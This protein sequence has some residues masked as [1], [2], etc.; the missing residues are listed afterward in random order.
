ML[1]TGATGFI[2]SRL[3]ALA[4]ARGYKVRTLS[5][6]DWSES[7]AVPVENRYF[8]SLPGKVPAVALQGTDLVVHCAA[9]VSDGERIAR[10]VNVDGTVQLARQAA[11]A[12]VRTFIFLSSQSA[13]LDAPSAYGKTKF[14]A[15]Q[16]LAA[17]SGLNIIILRPGL[18]VGPGRGGLYRRLERT[19]RE[20]PVLPLLDG[21]RA[22]V[23]PIH[24]DDLCE[25]IFRCDLQADQ[26]DRAVLC[27]GDVQGLPLKDFLQ[28]IA[29]VQLGHPKWA[30]DI[31]LWPVEL[32]VRLAEMLKLP[33]PVD[34][35]NLQGLRAVQRMDTAPTLERLGLQLRSVQDMVR[36]DEHGPR[37][38]AVPPLATR[39]V[40]V[41]LVGAGRV[42]LVHAV[43]LSRL[44]GIHLVGLVD[45]QPT[46][47]GL[48]QGVGVAAP[49][50]TE[51][52][53]ALAR[54]KPDAAV[55][56]T[57]VA[58]HLSL[59]RACLER[60]LAVMVEK[61]LAIRAD[62]LEDYERL[63]Q[64]RP[65]AS[66]QVGY[67]MLR[68]PQVVTSLERLRAGEYGAIR[69]FIGLSLLSFIREPRS[70]RWEVRRDLS[71]GGAFINSGG[72]VLSMIVAACGQP[73]SVTAETT[74][75]FSAEVED[76]LVAQFEYPGFRGTHYC[77]WSI[78]GY[79][80]QENLLAIETD[81]GRLVLTGSVGVFVGHDGKLDVVHQLDFDVG[82]NMAP[83]YVG[84]GFSTELTDLARA[85][86]T[87][88]LSPVG[89]DTVIPLE[90][91]LFSIYE[92]AREVP[93]FQQV[94]AAPVS[95]P[96]L[97]PKL[98]VPIPLPPSTETPLRRGLDLRE[99]SVQVA[100]AYLG[101]TGRAADWNEY[102]LSP[103]QVQ[104]L[105]RAWPPQ[106]RLQVSVPD[107]LAQ[108]RLLA[109]GRYQH[110]VRD[111][112]IAG[113]LRAGLAAS[114]LLLTER[115]L[116]FWIAAMALLAADLQKIPAWFRGTILL[117]GALTDLALSVR[118]LDM[119]ERMLALC[120]RRHRRARI[121]F[122]TSLAADAVDA[123]QVLAARV[124]A[125]SVLTSPRA[126]GMA[127]ML[128][129]IRKAGGHPGRRITA[130]V[131][132]APAI[133]HQAAALAPDRWAFGADSVLVGAVADPTL[134]ARCRDA[135][136]RAWASAFPGLDLVDA[137]V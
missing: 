80:R 78:E 44:H 104:S 126:R 56:A 27:L 62:Q 32:A 43:T 37:G 10:A 106:D 35:T 25:A 39:A 68:N 52:D 129:A 13:R 53:D 122:H 94:A 116:T 28:T 108:S 20:L 23:Q 115:K 105:R 130:E 4:L 70:K 55:I 60:G 59:A 85:V 29:A 57:P 1:V 117:H 14:L 66:L 88:T 77:S 134:R 12:G 109:T 87:G 11:E 119:L 86:R 92:R 91:L 16:A 107:F 84:A 6:S 76:S 64:R 72:H 120:R 131:G 114:P 26:L 111:M 67:V 9:S 3:A 112:G 40:R 61:P 118:R 128:S 98:T 65:G 124:D 63:V 121:G 135:A 5:R 71:G 96:S 30:L 46:A 73:Q 21:G 93:K 31:P 51:L 8:S 83:D 123:L 24:V 7:P 34:R 18:V 54:A 103:N 110:V 45:R 127:S 99:L 79:P 97:P 69:G 102:L 33:L 2:G 19:V 58:S 22:P 75:L 89:L 82:F 41:L 17:V 136:A 90:R 100:H 132:L 15:E 47:I 133:V 36:D 81:Q 49:A 125:V 48:L 95:A 38:E 137:V 101:T 42:G 50:Y 74:R 113:V